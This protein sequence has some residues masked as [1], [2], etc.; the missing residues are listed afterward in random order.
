MP[1]R[2][3]HC[4][5]GSASV[6]VRTTT[7]PPP[8]A[9]ACTPGSSVSASSPPSGDHRQ[10]WID[11]ASSMLVGGEHDAGPVD[12]GDGAD[13]QVGRRHRL[14]VDQ[15]APGPIAVGARDERAVAQ[16]CAGTPGTRSTHA[17][18]RSSASRS[19]A[20]VDGSIRRI[21]SARWS[22]LC[23]VMI[24][25]ASLQLHVGEVRE[26][27]AI[28]LHVDDR[29]VEADDVQRHVGVAGARGR[30]R[31]LGGHGR[32]IGGIAEVP[33][34]HRRRVDT[35]DGEGGAVGAPPVA[36]VAAHLLGGDEV[37]RAPRH[38]LRLVGVTAG[39]QAPA[40]VELADAQEAPVDV[41]HPL[42]QRIGPG[43]EHRAGHGQLA[44]RAADQAADEQ[45]PADGERRD[46]DGGVRGEGGDPAR[47][48][49]DPL[50]ACP[51][52]GRQGLVVAP[53]E[54]LG[55]GDEALLA[56]GGVDDP[57]AVDRV[58]AAAAAQEHDAPAVRRHDDVARLAEREAL[59][60]GRLARIRV[61]VL[62]LGA[63]VVGREE[64]TL[65]A[66]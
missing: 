22:R 39:Q 18:S 65:I 40:T 64:S 60:A 15:Q 53:A 45:P 25:P 10:T 31:Q 33:A 62:W 32:R 63:S 24:S 56:G 3:A 13:L 19:V 44:G 47:R 57:E 37:G 4:P 48:L 46:G 11:V 16:R 43:I 51:F 26:G 54:D 28:P 38:R 41:R 9:T 49:A 61:G 23:T 29:T 55:V 1:S 52:L 27:V 8:A 5:P 17:S 34:L 7:V 14:A 30:I 12:R 2:V 21:S 59:G 36:A 58:G 42:R 50:A 66:G 6:A 20:P 35:G